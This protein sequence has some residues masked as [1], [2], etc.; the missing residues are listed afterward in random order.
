MVGG[1]H[2]IN[3]KYI[4]SYLNIFSAMDEAS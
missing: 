2:K 3:I 4:K 1:Y